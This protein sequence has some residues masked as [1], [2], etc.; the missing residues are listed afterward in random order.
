M[1]QTFSKNMKKE[2]VQFF[3]PMIQNI[4]LKR[5][6]LLTLL[7]FFA[8][9]LTFLLTFVLNLVRNEC[10]FSDLRNKIKSKAFNIMK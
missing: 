9:F 2:A 3:S 4:D 5:Y 6:C 10:L 8:F 1:G 7:L